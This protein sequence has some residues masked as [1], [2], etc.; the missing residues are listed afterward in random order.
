MRQ[1][2]Q[3]QIYFDKCFVLLFVTGNTKLSLGFGLYFVRNEQIK[4][5]RNS[6]Q[7]VSPH[8]N[9]NQPKRKAKNNLFSDNNCSTHAVLIIL[10]INKNWYR[11]LE[12]ITMMSQFAGFI[13]YKCW[14]TFMLT[15]TNTFCWYFQ[16]Y[17]YKAKDYNRNLS[18]FLV[19]LK[20]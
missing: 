8:I 6:N 15:L 12:N 20:E 19:V 2:V 11:L 7:I 3:N 13:K 10:N 5:F 17:N 14:K 9:L 16:E 18:I 4:G 1:F